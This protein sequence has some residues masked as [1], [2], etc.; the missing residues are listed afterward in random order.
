MQFEDG[1]PDGRVTLRLPTARKVTYWSHLEAGDWQP[2]EVHRGMVVEG[3]IS[4]V[5]T[6][7]NIMGR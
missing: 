1:R 4:R 3:A 5:I 2:V 7:V 6:P